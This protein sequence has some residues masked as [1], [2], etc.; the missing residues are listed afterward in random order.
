MEIKSVRITIPEEFV[1]DSY[2]IGGIGTRAK[3]IINTYKKGGRLNPNGW[4]GFDNHYGKD[5]LRLERGIFAPDGF[6]TIC[7]VRGSVLFMTIL[8]EKKKGSK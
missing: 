3:E 7:K 8:N 4:E 6:A 5:Y 1:G 2:L